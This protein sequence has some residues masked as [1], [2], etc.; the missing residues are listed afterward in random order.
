MCGKNAEKIYIEILCFYYA[1]SVVVSGK[2]KD[3]TEG[4]DCIII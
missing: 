3:M 4:T 1:N 2:E